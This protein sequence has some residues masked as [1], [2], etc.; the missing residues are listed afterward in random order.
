[1]SI[2]P[3]KVCFYSLTNAIYDEFEVIGIGFSVKID[4]NSRTCP[5]DLPPLPDPKTELIRQEFIS[6][7]LA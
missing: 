5:D 4:V 1:M 7:L 3:A 6:K 2:S